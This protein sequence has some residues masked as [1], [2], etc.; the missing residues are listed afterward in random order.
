MERSADHSI[1]NDWKNKHFPATPC[2]KLAYK[3][4]NEAIFLLSI[5]TRYHRLALALPQ[6]VELNRSSGLRLIGPFT[7]KSRFYR[8]S[9]RTRNEL[10]KFLQIYTRE[11]CLV[12]IFFFFFPHLIQSGS[13]EFFNSTSKYWDRML[14]NECISL[15]I[16][17]LS[18]LE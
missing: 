13:H 11:K 3:S 10:L 1:R 9:K 12:Y 2:F 15:F 5:I 8:I 6:F 16:L 4:V 18:T 14:F 17:V 7:T